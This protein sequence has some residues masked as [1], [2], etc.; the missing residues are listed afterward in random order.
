MPGRED[1][2]YY[3]TLIFLHI[4]FL[5]ITFLCC[6]V[7]VLRAAV[8]TAV[9]THRRVSNSTPACVALIQVRLHL[10]HFIHH[11]QELTMESRL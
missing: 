7:A 11:P 4:V 6:P 3:F 5:H 1:R 8:C 2:E 9:S 10:F